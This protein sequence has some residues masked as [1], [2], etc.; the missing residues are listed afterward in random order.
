MSSLLTNSYAPVG[1]DAVSEGILH[2]D[3]VVSALV[4]YEASFSCFDI[5]SG[6]PVPIH[7][8]DFVRGE[9][10]NGSVGS[11]VGEFFT[12]RACA[13]IGLKVIDGFTGFPRTISSFQIVNESFVDLGTG[14]SN[15]V[16]R[17]SALFRSVKKSR[18][19]TESINDT[20][21]SF[22][23]SR[24]PLSHDDVVRC[25]LSVHRD[26]PGEHTRQ[27]PCYGVGC[28]K[29]WVVGD[30]GVSKHDLTEPVVLV[31]TVDVTGTSGHKEITVGVKILVGV[32]GRPV[33]GVNSEPLAVFAVGISTGSGSQSGS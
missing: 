1:A 22:S 18:D 19:G 3:N 29:G 32:V 4:D 17:H 20:E 8:R 27:P 14:I 21:V 26:H 16:T 15:G 23:P 7:E 24:L 12:S 6:S 33:S 10:R 13:V 31:N 2:P 9:L 28:N 5:S 30:G 11:I 25:G